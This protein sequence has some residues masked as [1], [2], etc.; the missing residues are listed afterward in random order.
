MTDESYFNFRHGTDF[1]FTRG[2]RRGLEPMQPAFQ[3]VTESLSP[4]VK[5]PGREAHRLPPSS[6]EVENAWS[7]SLFISA[8]FT[9]YVVLPKN[10]GNLNRAP[11]TVV[12]CP[13]SSMLC[14]S[15]CQHL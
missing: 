10:S 7:Y 9:T 14:E 12:V 3:C 8:A 6:A 1:L 13:A 4:R 5:R 15:V 11:G 2:L